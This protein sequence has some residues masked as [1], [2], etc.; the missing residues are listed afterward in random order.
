MALVADRGEQPTQLITSE[1]KRGRTGDAVSAFAMTFANMLLI[2]PVDKVVLYQTRKPRIPGSFEDTATRAECEQAW[3]QRKNSEV[4]STNGTARKSRVVHLASSVQ[5]TQRGA[6]SWGRRVPRFVHEESEEY[7][8]IG[9]MRGGYRHLK[10]VWS[11]PGHEV[12][13]EQY[14]KDGDGNLLGDKSSICKRWERY[15]PCC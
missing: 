2:E 6:P 5:T 11:L 4:D 14:V 1:L 13:S 8:I 9:D 10:G 3:D 15:S 12:E 7:T